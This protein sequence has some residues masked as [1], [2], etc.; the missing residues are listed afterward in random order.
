MPRA[1]APARRRMSC[2]SKAVDH[3]GKATDPRLHQTPSVE[4]MR[5]QTAKA[6][7]TTPSVDARRFPVEVRE[8]SLNMH[9]E[10]GQMTTASSA[11][12][13]RLPIQRASMTSDAYAHKISAATAVTLSDA[14][15]CPR[16]RL[17][18]CCGGPSV[19]DG[20]LGGSREASRA[21]PACQGSVRVTTP[22]DSSSTPR[23][24]SSAA[25]STRVRPWRLSARACS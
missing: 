3:T 2:R 9:Q 6:W 8:A 13:S 5:P 16:R 22:M 10:S 24:R 15:S 23:R 19:G 17:T 7:I 18:A 25:T 21:S 14:L 1:T 12:A 20:G 4:T 11:A